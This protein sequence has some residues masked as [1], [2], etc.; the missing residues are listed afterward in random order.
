[1]ARRVTL[2]STL[3]LLVVMSLLAAIPAAADG[4]G[5]PTWDKATWISCS[6][7]DAPGGNWTA[8][9]TIAKGE[10]KWFAWYPVT[11]ADTGVAIWSD[12]VVPTPP[13]GPG[14]HFKVYAFVTRPWGLS[15]K[16]IG[17]STTF[18]RD[19]PYTRKSWRGG[20]LATTHYFQ[21]KNLTENTA[22]FTMQLNCQNPEKAGTY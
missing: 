20:L 3:V 15:L 18:G 12:A 1:V 8:K 21:V 22:S 7:W 6:T 4:P 17:Q 19:W 5:G 2:I 11:G 14:V 16:E 10:E 9:G 13:G